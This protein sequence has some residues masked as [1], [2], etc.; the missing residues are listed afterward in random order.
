GV[1]DALKLGEDVRHVGRHSDALEVRDGGHVPRGDQAA[2]P[3]GESVFLEAPGQIRKRT[4]IPLTLVWRL[5]DF[6]LEILEDLLEDEQQFA[7]IFPLREV[8]RAVIT[9][10]ERTSLCAGVRSV[11]FAQRNVGFIKVLVNRPDYVV[12]HKEVLQLVQRTL[13]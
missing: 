5:L 11:V 1:F 8:E 10:N 12:A 7:S 9:N 3:V 6:Q 2:I 13:A 4:L